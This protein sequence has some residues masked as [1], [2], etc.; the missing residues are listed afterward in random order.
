MKQKLEMAQLRRPPNRLTAEEYRMYKLDGMSWEEKVQFLG[1]N[2]GTAT[3]SNNDLRSQALTRDKLITYSILRLHG[4]SFPEIKA[5]A[6]PTRSFPDAVSLRS[7][8]E[9]ATYLQTQAAFPFFMKP[10]GG[11]AGAGSVWV[12][13][14]AD[15]KLQLRNGDTIPLEKYFD[16]WRSFEG[17]VLQAVARPHPEIAQRFGPRLATARVVVLMGE[18]GPII[19]RAVLRIPA[20]K[21]MI[22]NFR[23]GASGNLLGAIEVDSG[24]VSNVIGKKGNQLDT[25]PTHPDTGEQIIGFT[26]PDWEKA[27]DL[28]VQAAP[29]FPGIMYQS[30]DIAFTEEG[31]QTIEVNSGG[32]VDV[33][34][35]ASGRGIADATWW[36]LF[37]EPKPGN[38]L[39]RWM[40]RSGPWKRHA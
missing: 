6:H 37:R 39:R 21:N 4:F 16:R 29:L 17:I 35:L 30:W 25:I 27:K 13:G 14:Y 23:H 38:V 28:C 31:P 33:L 18:D 22:D 15:G 10:I 9:I 2:S 20:G 5:V 12:D 3:N 34:Q 40:V 7:V 8:Q 1:V 24:L 32:D 19:H 26:L 36:K 11:N